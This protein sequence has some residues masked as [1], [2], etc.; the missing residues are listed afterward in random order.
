MFH[1][2][3]YKMT[4]AG[5]PLM[6]LNKRTLKYVVI[7]TVRG[8]GYDC[9][10]DTVATFE[11]TDLGLWNK[12]SNWVYFIKGVMHHMGEPVCY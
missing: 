1:L 10:T 5:G 12:V 2:Q 6:Y 4:N 7:G 11:K 3:D 9:R 8:N